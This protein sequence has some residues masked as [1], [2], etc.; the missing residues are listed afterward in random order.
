MKE[1]LIQKTISKTAMV[2]FTMLFAQT[3]IANDV[4]YCTSELATGIVKKKGSWV[5]SSFKPERFTIK[6]ADD[7]SSVN[8]PHLDGTVMDCKVLYPP[9]PELINCSDRV[10]GVLNFNKENTRF[11]Y[12]AGSLFGYLSDLSDTNTLYAGTCE[13]F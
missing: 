12:F 3:A 4:L 2:V 7:F 6:F 10:G 9:F 1:M 11:V 13:K 8:H 5:E